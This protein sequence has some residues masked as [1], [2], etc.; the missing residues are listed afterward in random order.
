MAALAAAPRPDDSQQLVEEALGRA[1]AV[2]RASSRTRSFL[3]AD[4]K[5]TPHVLG[6][7]LARTARNRLA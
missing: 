2:A 5:G 6:A 7:T 4:K 1:L 3:D